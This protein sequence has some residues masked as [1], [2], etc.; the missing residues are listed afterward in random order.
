MS[1]VVRSRSASAAVLTAVMALSAPVALADGP[2]TGD[3]SP[4]YGGSANDHTAPYLR[5]TLRTKHLGTLASSGKLK[6]LLAS[7][8]ASLVGLSGKLTARAPH[9]KTLKLKLK[10]TSLLFKRAG[11]KNATLTLTSAS[12]T[13]LLKFWRAGGKKVRGTV[14]VT[15]LGA[16]GAHNKRSLRK[17]GALTR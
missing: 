14:L 13:K 1:R 11:Q 3:Q 4:S 6:L 8:E 10:G 16:D 15:G 12:R 17:S 5:A 2:G 9:A 7:S